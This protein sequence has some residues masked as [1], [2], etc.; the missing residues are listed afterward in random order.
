MYHLIGFFRVNPYISRSTNYSETQIIMTFFKK[1]Y[2][3]SEKII[4]ALTA[5]KLVDLKWY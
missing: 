4:R 3:N 5:E 1:T 2:L